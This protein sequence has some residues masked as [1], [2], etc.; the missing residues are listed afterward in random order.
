[1]WGGVLQRRPQVC[2]GVDKRV[3]NSDSSRERRRDSSTCILPTGH[4]LCAAGS[5]L[6]CNPHAQEGC[7]E[8]RTCSC[9]SGT[10]MYRPS[11]C[12]AWVRSFLLAGRFAREGS[13]HTGGD[14]SDWEW[15][16]SLG[17]SKLGWEPLNTFIRH[18][19]GRRDDELKG[20]WA[21][22]RWSQPLPPSSQSFQG[23]RKESR[24]CLQQQHKGSDG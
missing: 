13:R 3:R 24:F 19:L 21:Q 22:Q 11:A 10:W 2:S 7:E 16:W 5:V 20:G 12:Q 6:T 23:S 15:L 18:L 1:M 17:G 14:P 8:Q 9:P 4:Q